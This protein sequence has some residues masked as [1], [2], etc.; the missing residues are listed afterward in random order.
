MSTNEPEPPEA[1]FTNEPIAGNGPESPPGKKPSASLL[2]IFG[3]ALGEGAVSI[4]I[5][6]VS[7]FA[8]L[9]YIQVLGLSPAYAGIALSITVFWDAITD[10]VMGHLTDAT[11]SR[12]GRRLPYVLLGGIALGVSYFLLWVLPG[13]FD[14]AI[15]IFWAI[16]LLNLVLR[17]MM[18]VFM[19]PYTALGFEMCPD[20]VDRARLQ[21]VRYFLNQMVNL[22][23]G[24]FAWV[25]WFQNVTQPDGSELD[26]TQIYENYISMAIWASSAILIMVLIC[27]WTTRR[28]SI[29]NRHDEKKSNS[30]KA[31]YLNFAQVFRD[32]LAWFVFGF[33]GIAQFAMLLVSQVQMFTYVHYMEFSAG[34]KTFVHGGTMVAFALGAL[35]LLRLVRWFDKKTVGFIGLTLSMIGGLML[36]VCFTGFNLLEPKTTLDILPGLFPEGFP[37]GVVVFGLFQWFWWGGCGIVVPLA[38]SMIADVSEINLRV[39]GELKDGSYS[40]MF[41]FFLKA[42]TSV[43]LFV[44]GILISLSGFDTEAQRQTEASSITIA[45]MTFLSGPIIVILSMLV[46]SRYPI[47]RKYMDEMRRKYPNPEADRIARQAKLNQPGPDSE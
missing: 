10:P 23:F 18:T 7:N 24:A 25:L 21:G 15:I 6:G 44:T 39:N 35:S 14:T 22:L 9:F 31:M 12:F 27:V 2:Q 40:A 37:L 47:N 41:S 3:Y 1:A 20:Y 32:K 45:N 46:L 19:V 4:T 5:N 26:G 29:D 43:G 33:F 16:L 28:Y 11:R 42:A 8:M 36:Y 13:Q 38:T 17:T 30:P 34:E